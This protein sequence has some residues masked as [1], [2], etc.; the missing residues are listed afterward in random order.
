MQDNIA[1]CKNFHLQITCILQIYTTLLHGMASGTAPWKFLQKLNT[2]G[3]GCVPRSAL[4]ETERRRALGLY[5]GGV[6]SQ[7]KRVSLISSQTHRA[8]KSNLSRYPRHHMPQRR[9]QDGRLW[10]PIP[11]EIHQHGKF[12]F[13]YVARK[14][15]FYIESICAFAFPIIRYAHRF[16]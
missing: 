3:R 2:T 4:A 7:R 8:L 11:G 5:C 16:S 13:E 14:F 10:F 15:P 12:F 6:S 9:P 1:V